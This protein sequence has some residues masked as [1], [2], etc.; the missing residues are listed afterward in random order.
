MA[1]AGNRQREP[2]SEPIRIEKPGQPVKHEKPGKPES[3]RL[4]GPADGAPG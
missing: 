4:R 3:G 1:C 2:P